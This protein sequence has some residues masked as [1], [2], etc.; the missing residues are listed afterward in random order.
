MELGSAAGVGSAGAGD[1]GDSAADPAAR[2]AG[3]GVGSSVH[4]DAATLNGEYLKDCNVTKSSRQGRDLDMATKLWE[5]SE[6]IVAK[7]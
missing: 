7:V 5:T 6:A 1:S 3:S 2:T 4:P